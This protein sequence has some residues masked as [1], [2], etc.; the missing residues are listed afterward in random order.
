MTSIF[1]LSVSQWDRH[2][3]DETK[4][5]CRDIALA[6]QIASTVGST[7]I[8]PLALDRWLIHGDP[9][10]YVVWVALISHQFDVL[11]SRRMFYCEFSAVQYSRALR[12][13][14]NPDNIYDIGL[15]YKIVEYD[16]FIQD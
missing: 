11:K 12:F 6:T 13:Q 3:H 16:I 5:K 14:S 1:V 10:V 9:R 15:D 8:R 7:S 2:P 4:G